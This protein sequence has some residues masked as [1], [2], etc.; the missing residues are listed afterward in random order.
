PVLRGGRFSARFYSHLIWH[1][2]GKPAVA[3]PVSAYCDLVGPHRTGN[4]DPSRADGAGLGGAG[5]GRIGASRASGAVIPPTACGG[6][7]ERRW[8][9][10]WMPAASPARPPPR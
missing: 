2:V 1:G 3:V 9:G 8:R 4:L 10:C 5:L 6:R 7:R